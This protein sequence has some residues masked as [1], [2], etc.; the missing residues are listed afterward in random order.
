MKKIKFTEEELK[1]TINFAN[2]I[3]GKHPYFKDKNNLVRRTENE[4]FLSVVR[5][6]LAEIA[7]H[8]H[9]KEKHKGEKIYLSDLDFNIYEKGI[10]DDFDLKF[11]D[12]NISIKSSKPFSTCMLIEKEKF[13]VDKNNKVIAIDGHSNNIPDY[14]AFIKVDFNIEDMHDSYAII[15]GAISHKSFW[16]NKKEIPRGTFINQ[17]NMYNLLILNKPIESLSK[18]KGMPLI[19]TNYGIHINK[20]KPI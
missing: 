13:K 17:D 7:L 19:A 14:Y 11:N 12:L 18:N 3:K 20:F 10:C 9:L 16:K 2:K 5:G 8:K 4:V 6:K 1:K 15:C